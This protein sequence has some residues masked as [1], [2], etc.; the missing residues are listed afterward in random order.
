MAAGVHE[1]LFEGGARV[2]THVPPSRV[3]S[4]TVAIEDLTAS[5]DDTDRFVLSASAADVDSYSATTTAAAG[6]GQSDP[7]L[8]THDGTAG[9]AGTVY[10]I[11]A[12]DG[13]H[14]LFTTEAVTG[15]TLR[16]AVPLTGRFASGSTVRGVQLSCTFPAPAAADADLFEADVPL[17]VRWSYTATDGTVWRVDELVRLVRGT[18]S[19]R[20]LAAIELE[21]RRTKPEL[22]RL[23]GTQPSM[24]RDL[25]ASVSR[26]LTADLR[27]KG[28]EPDRYFS[29]DEGFELLKQACV[30]EIAED[31]IAP[32]NV[33]AST[34]AAM[35]SQ[36]FARMWM[37]ATR[38]TDSTV[39]A[40]LT[41]ADDTAPAGSSRA[42]RSPW[43]R[44]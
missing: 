25:V 27:S 38:G 18:S 6:A 31:G 5:T 30:L 34:Y 35:Q 23:L 21:L 17:R 15:S 29:G 3:A 22:V 8:V 28:I 20:H 19:A 32:A 13:Q 43:R 1:V 40:E 42:R 44:G 16:S 24:L 10:E 14:E 36:K 11:T 26:R 7:R 39:A 33:D 41:R 2:L 37:A 4:A 12:P 9:T